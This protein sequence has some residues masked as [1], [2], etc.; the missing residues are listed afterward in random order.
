MSVGLVNPGTFLMLQIH[1]LAELN[2]PVNLESYERNPKNL[3]NLQ[4]FCNT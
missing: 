4:L 1:E 3:N 2:C